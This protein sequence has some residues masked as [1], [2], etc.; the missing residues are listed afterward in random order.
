MVDLCVLWRCGIHT[1]KIRV[2]D[3]CLIRIF[4]VNDNKSSIFYRNANFLREP[5]L[6]LRVNLTSS[7]GLLHISKAD[8]FF[9]S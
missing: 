4:I 3:M 6:V 9:S 1:L 7:Y 2:V 5:S 8:A